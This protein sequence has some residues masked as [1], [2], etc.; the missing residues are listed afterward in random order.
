M[1]A[2]VSA[3]AAFPLFLDDLDLGSASKYFD[4]FKQT[5]QQTLHA[6]VCAS[7]SLELGQLKNNKF[8]GAC[9]NSMMGV[10]NT[11]ECIQYEQKINNI[12]DMF[13]TYVL[14]DFCDSF[15]HVEQ[16]YNELTHN[17]V[18]CQ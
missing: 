17:L 3:F 14:S 6:S 5:K 13:V 8:P 7:L 11:D 10:S 1:A 2:C 4:Q 15:E 12:I 18:G 16:A 9:A